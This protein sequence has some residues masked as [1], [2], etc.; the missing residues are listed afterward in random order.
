MRTFYINRK[1]DETGISGT[2]VV[3]EGVEFADGTCVIRWC[4]DTA[5][6]NFYNSTEEMIEI[7]GHGGRTVLEWHSDRREK[8]R[9]HED[10]HEED[11]HAD[12]DEYLKGITERDGENTL[13]GWFN[14]ISK[15]SKRGGDQ[16]EPPPDWDGIK[17][18]PGYQPDEV[19]KS[20]PPGDE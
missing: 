19:L 11:E 5:S 7:H 8:L 17:G 12:Q 14:V 15:N 9:E 2:G 6:T 1:E 20:P 18:N 4:T 3:A 10:E 13:E 16:P